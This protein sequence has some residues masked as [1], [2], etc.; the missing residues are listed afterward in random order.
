M[1]ACHRR[2]A[3]AEVAQ[4]YDCLSGFV[5]AMSFC[6]R[7]AN[8]SITGLYSARTAGGRDRAQGPIDGFERGGLGATVSSAGA[9]R[10]GDAANWNKESEK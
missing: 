6:Y 1:G 9:N 5:F 4:R 8:L 3:I 2:D 7:T 10:C